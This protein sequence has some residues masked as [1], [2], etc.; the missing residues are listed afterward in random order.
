MENSWVEIKYKD[1]PA[2]SQMKTFYIS[3]KFIVAFHVNMLQQL[4]LSVNS[5]NGKLE[6]IPSRTFQPPLLGLAKSMY[7]SLFICLSTLEIWQKWC[8]IDDRYV[9]HIIYLVV[10]QFT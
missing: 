3:I 4:H 5:I 10:T 2:D 1:L 9:Q 6:E 8:R 7:Y